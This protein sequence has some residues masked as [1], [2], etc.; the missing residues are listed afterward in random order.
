M[1]GDAG[2]VEG[3]GGVLS[4]VVGDGPDGQRLA[5]AGQVGSV[6]DGPGVGLRAEPERDRGGAGV[7]GWW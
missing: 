7:R 1:A 2:R 5:G 3:L 4:D 6:P